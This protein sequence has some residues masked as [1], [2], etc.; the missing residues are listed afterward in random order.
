MK[1]QPNVNQAPRRDDPASAKYERP[2]IR[3]FTEDE[4]LV[5]LGPA[6]LYNGSLP[7]QF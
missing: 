7:F 6:Q 1:N 3:V 5:Q 2:S 4:I